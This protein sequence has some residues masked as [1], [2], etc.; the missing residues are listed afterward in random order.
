MAV[1]A[2]ETGHLVFA[3]LHTTN[4]VRSIDRII[5]VFPAKE[6]DQIRSMVSESMRGVIC[7][8]LI[9]DRKSTR[10]NSSHGYISYAVFC[11][12]KKK[13]EAESRRLRFLRRRTGRDG[14]Q[15]FSKVGKVRTQ[16]SLLV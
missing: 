2:A 5:D 10:L 1:T 9:P 11:L 3:T 16:L 15:R 7:Q 12:K 8:Q 4:A 14:E 6:Q 13:K